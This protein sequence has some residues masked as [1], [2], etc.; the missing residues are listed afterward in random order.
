MKKDDILQVGLLFFLVG[1]IIFLTIVNQQIKNSI[2]K[3]DLPEEFNE[4]TISKDRANPTE[5]MAIY[6]TLE[7][8]YIIEFMDK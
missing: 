3:I 8:K 4:H 7:K 6:D 1:F 5:L 2:P